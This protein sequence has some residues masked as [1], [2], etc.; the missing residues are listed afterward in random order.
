[1]SYQFLQT[2]TEGRT[3]VIRLNRPEV[4]NALNHQ[5]LEELHQ[6]VKAFIRDDQWLG[7]IIT[8]AGEKAFAAGADIAQ[9][10]ALD[11]IGARSASAFGQDVFFEIEQSPKPVIAAVNGFALGGGCELAMACHIRIASEK[12]RFGQPEVKLGLVAGY[13]GTQRLTRLIGRSRATELLI[14]AEMIG[15][16]DALRLGLVNYVV[17]PDALLAKCFELL[18]KAYTQSPKAVALTLEAID[19]YYSQAHGFEAE[20][21]CFARA[22]ASHDGKEGTKAFLEK[23]KAEFTGK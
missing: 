12:A 18:E 15:A 2:E 10:A 8:G 14:T 3:L 9:L 1:M 5:L 23:R 17:A 11:E 7:A 21:D 16:E 4:L 6:A 19:A 22:M 13:G 20:Q